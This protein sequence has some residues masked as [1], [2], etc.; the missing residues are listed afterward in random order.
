MGLEDALAGE[1]P[2][3]IANPGQGWNEQRGECRMGTATLR[4]MRRAVLAR[5]VAVARLAVALIGGREAT[6][7]REHLN[8]PR[9]LD[10]DRCK[11]DGEKSLPRC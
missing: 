3:D 10:G 5:L 7:R 9:E 1:L 6:L 4:A 11:R 8:E 2:H